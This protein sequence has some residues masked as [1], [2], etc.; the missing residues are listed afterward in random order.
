[1][2]EKMKL[3]GVDFTVW[4]PIDAVLR[5]K[6]VKMHTPQIV[7]CFPKWTP[8]NWWKNHFG[9]KQLIAEAAWQSIAYEDSMDEYVWDCA[10]TRLEEDTGR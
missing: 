6:R 9:Q 1:M 2:Y 8:G 10:V 5:K 3:M 7:V 4:T